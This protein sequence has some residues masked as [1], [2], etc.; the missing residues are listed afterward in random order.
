MDKK[1]LRIAR[2]KIDQLDNR[3]FSLI[4]KRT[5]IVKYM[6]SLKQ[7]RNQIVDRKRI[8]EILKNIENRSIKEGIDSKITPLYYEYNTPKHLL[9]WWWSSTHLNLYIHIDM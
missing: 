3:I 4:K 9:P 6:M 5:R 2:K 7:F 8:N 1:K